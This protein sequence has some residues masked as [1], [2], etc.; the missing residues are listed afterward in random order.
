MRKSQGK[1][2]THSTSAAGYPREGGGRKGR[3]L[4]GLR[5]R[6]R[7]RWRTIS[8]ARKYR[9]RCTAAQGRRC[10]TRRPRASRSS[11]LRF[12][13]GQGAAPS[14]TFDQIRRCSG[15]CCWRWRH[16]AAD[17]GGGLGAELS[18]RRGGYCGRSRRCGRARGAS[19]RENLSY[20]I[21]AQPDE[22]A[23]WRA[24][25]TTWRTSLQVPTARAHAARA[26]GRCCARFRWASSR[27][28]ARASSPRSTRRRCACWAQSGAWARSSGDLVR[29]DQLVDLARKTLEQ[30]QGQT[31][32]R[33]TDRVLRWSLRP[34][35]TRKRRGNGRGA[36]HQRHDAD[37]PALSS[38]GRSSSP[39][40]RTSSRRR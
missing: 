24:T 20:R 40:R 32:E 9:R 38:C 26:D 5:R 13:T 31:A 30:S 10:A 29:D 18:R 4:G 25:S 19:R 7:G 2:G 21:P 33:T 8:S 28:T 37:A 27:W 35:A 15:C 3:A 16:S 39:T 14:Q 23:P 6:R 34:S 11:T 17:A 12:P 36:G 22:M 1:G